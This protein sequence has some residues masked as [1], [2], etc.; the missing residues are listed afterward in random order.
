MTK[1]ENDNKNKRGQDSTA[2]R[3]ETEKVN[4][5]KRGMGGMMDEK[6]IRQ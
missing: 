1:R 2:A 4:K 3:L 5:S 6:G